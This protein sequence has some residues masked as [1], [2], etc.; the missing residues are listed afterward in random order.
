MKLYVIDCYS[1]KSE[2]E[3]WAEYLSIVKPQGAEYFGRNLDAFWDALS[4]GGPGFPNHEEKC[5]IRFINTQHVK[6]FRNGEF[7]NKLQEIAQD[8][9]IETNYEISL[10]LS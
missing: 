6:L 2:A 1:I 7:Y 8:L 10:N 5:E 3:F 4:A 9:K